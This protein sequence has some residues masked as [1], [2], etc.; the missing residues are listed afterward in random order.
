MKPV[1]SYEETFCKILGKT[2]S[3]ATQWCDICRCC[4]DTN[5]NIQIK[6]YMNILKTEFKHFLF[7]V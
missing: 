3:P 4:S 7:L 2:Y 1:A 5:L 6:N